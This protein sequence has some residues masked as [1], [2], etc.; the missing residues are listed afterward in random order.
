MRRTSTRPSRPRATPSTSGRETSWEGRVAIFRD[1]ADVIR[2]A[3]SDHSVDG[4]RKCKNT[5]RRRLR[6]S[7][8]AI[9]FLRYYSSELERNEG[10]TADT[11]EPTPGQRCV[12]DLQPYGVFGV[13]AP[14]NFR[15]RS[16][17][18]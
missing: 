10:Y 14:F 2:T 13:V 6:R 12:S 7:T 8:K 4:L 11:H 5:E 3:N 18:E 1:A 17:S 16:P 15:S 9:D